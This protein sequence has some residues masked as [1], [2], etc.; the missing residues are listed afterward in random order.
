M[1]CKN[2]LKPYVSVIDKNQYGILWIKILNDLFD[3]TDDLFICNTYILP[4]GSSVIDQN[5]FDFFEKLEFDI[6]KYKP[7]GKIFV[8]GDMNAR[9]GDLLDT[10]IFDKY[11]DYDDSYL[12]SFVD[13][14]PRANSDHVV[15][16][17]GRRLV[18]LCKTTSLLIGNGRLH[19][20]QIGEFTFHSH[21]G[22]ST[23]DYILLGKDD[24]KCISNFE[25]V[26]QNEFSD[27]S[28][29][30]F[31]VKLKSEKITCNSENPVK[32]AYIKLD[33][34]KVQQYKEMLSYSEH[35]I[36]SFT[37]DLDNYENN[38]EGIVSSFVNLLQDHAFSIFGKT[39]KQNKNQTNNKRNQEWFNSDCY[40]ARKLFKHARN[41][42]VKFK[43]D[44]NR[45]DF[46]NAKTHFNRIKR[47]EKNKFKSKQKVNLTKMAKEKPRQFW[48]KV[49]TQYTK[50]R[51]VAENLNINDIYTHFENLYGSDYQHADNNTF[52]RDT[53]GDDFLDKE[54][55]YD[56]VRRV[57]FQQ[58][59][60][61]SSGVDSLPAEIFKYS[62]DKIG[63]FLTKLFNRLFEN[64]EY[65]KSWGE[66]II[67]PIFK[68]GDLEDPKNYRGIT[69]INV[70]SKIYSQILL[71]RITTW[72]IDNEKIIHNQFGF[73]KGKSTTD[74]IF[75][76]HT[77]ITKCLNTN[78]KL[79]C[80][81]VDY[82]KC[83]DKI[84]RDLLWQNYLIKELVQKWLLHYKP[85]IVL[86]NNVSYIKVLSQ[87]S[88]HQISG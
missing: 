61:K 32:D 44:E 27:H 1:Y 48:N 23:V 84:N 67:V 71:N 62:F 49:K 30:N 72:S 4:A 21:N 15:D 81:F 60:N 58:N 38:I 79:Y 56:E 43:N 11:L 18:D 31:C 5:D 47:R 75:L 68:G 39:R 26:E 14:I 51:S 74:C 70:I 13:I 55:S 24:F 76:L 22:S 83:F 86:S 17:H 80:A 64:G 10:L 37:I 53:I 19:T 2:Y 35:I 34:T 52:D 40:N 87:T 45:R 3:F 88:S 57:V 9:T 65:P 41:K 59:N 63:N 16:S 42:F 82:E 8:T 54:I 28:G 36:S 33:E 20:D 66:G 77:I 25:I 12:S 78:K 7:L 50:H 6:E 46:I 85:C 73:Q 69:L 29:L